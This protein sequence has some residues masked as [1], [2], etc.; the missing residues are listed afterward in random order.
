MD[1]GVGMEKQERALGKPARAESLM[2][3]T[4]GQVKE[5][6]SFYSQSCWDL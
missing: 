3:E 5:D 2:E 6:V 4:V 1:L